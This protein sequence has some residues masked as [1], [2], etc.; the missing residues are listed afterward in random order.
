MAWF[1]KEKLKRIVIPGRKRVPDGLMQKCDS[2]GQMI[3]KKELLENVHVCPCCGYHF[4]LGAREKVGI[5]ADEDSF[6]EYDEN[7]RSVDPLEFEDTQK[8]SDRLEEAQRR[9]GL[10]EAVITGR[11]E[12]EEIPAILGALD[13]SFVGG[14]MGSVVGEKICRAVERAREESISLVTISSSGGARMQEGI[15]SLMQMSKTSAALG[16]LAEDRIPYIS[17]LAHPTTGGVAASFASL[18]DVIIAEPGALI[19]FAGARVIK[20]TIHQELPKGFQRAEFLLEHGM[21]DM[22]VPRPHLKATVARLL[23]FLGKHQ[24]AS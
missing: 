14:S 19:G 2:C 8:Y 5:L 17:I 16:R 10:A 6:R 13:F 12:I 22:V 21:I 18:G 1:R 3:Y 11:A 23:R 15:L 24:S 4:T 7:L 20:Q 9:T